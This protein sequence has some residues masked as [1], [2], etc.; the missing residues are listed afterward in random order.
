MKSAF[1]YGKIEDDVNV[2]QPKGYEMKGSEAKVYKL[3][4]ALYGLK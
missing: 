4:K 1:L 2:E 3:N